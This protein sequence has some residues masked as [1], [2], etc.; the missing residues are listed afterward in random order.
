VTSTGA[1]RPHP[2]ATAVALS[3]TLER[4]DDAGRELRALDPARHEAYLAALPHAADHVARRLIGALHRERLPGV[5]ASTH[6]IDTPKGPVA[7][8]WHGFGRAEPVGELPAPPLDLITDLGA[9]LG[10]GLPA[11]LG[12]AVATLALAYTCRPGPPAATGDPDALATGYERLATEGHNL[13]PCARTRLGWSVADTLAHDLEAGHTHVAFVGVRRDRLVGDDL[14]RALGVGGTRTHAAQPVHAWQLGH[15]RRTRADLFAAGVLTD[16]PAA[17]LPAT[18]TAALRTLHVPG[19][20]YLKLSLDIQVTSTRRTISVASSRNGPVLSA[21]LADL[22]A[23]EPVLLLAET[24]GSACADAPRDVTA[25]LRTG[26]A[27]ALRPDETALP[28]TALT[29]TPP[30]E[31][32]SVVGGLLRRDR[33]GALPFLASYARVLL[34]PLLRLATRHGIGL[35]AH[36]QNCL[37]VFRGG[38]PV[39]MVLRDVAGLRVHLPRLATRGHRPDLWPGS[40]VGTDD[41]TVMRSKLGYTALQAHL[42]ELVRHLADTAG[43]DDTAAWHAVRDIVDEVYDDL[44]RDPTVDPADAAADHAFWTAPRMPHKALVRM[45]L[46]GAGDLYVDVPNPLHGA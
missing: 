19:H 24:G 14:G 39:R 36:L 46:A 17:P 41:L 35:E 4:L 26:L 37:P 10:G 42:G 25:I 34:P 13:H 44:R 15:L 11:E 43:L 9:A 23:D 12:S 7:A 27:G 8:R 40:V 32:S 18:P 5:T 2:A 6:A 30:G 38:H 20:G 28:A 33:V 16:L 29:V 3:A 45:R 22:L 21:L 1:T 31:T